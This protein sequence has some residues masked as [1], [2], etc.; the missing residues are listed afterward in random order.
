MLCH[1][2]VHIIS[3]NLRDGRSVDQR[4]AIFVFG[5][6]RNLRPMMMK[7]VRF[8]DSKNTR[9]DPP[10]MYDYDDPLANLA[11]CRILTLL[12]GSQILTVPTS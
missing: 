1:Q 2:N 10:E 6:F 9:G 8:W 12:I 4:N 11:S 7:N 5:T 3:A